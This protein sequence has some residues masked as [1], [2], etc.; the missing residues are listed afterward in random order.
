MHIDYHKNFT[1][2]YS[3]LSQ[4]LKDKF[5]ERLKIFVDDSH[6]PELNNHAL[7]GEY[8]GCRS[9]NVTGDWRAVYEV[10]EHG[11][12]FLDIDTHGNLY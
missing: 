10:R 6:A 4:K 8:L 7:H 9:I 3:K 2:S 5:N 11:V 12:R 1:R